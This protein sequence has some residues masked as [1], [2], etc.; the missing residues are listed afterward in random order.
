MIELV[1]TS[2]WG[3]RERDR[4]VK[5]EIDAKLLDDEVATCDAVK[6]E[7]LYSARNATEF[8]AIRS[9]LDA[10]IAYPVGRGEW[11]RALDVYERLAEQGGNH[12]RQVKHMDL[13]VAAA[14]ESA[15]VPVLHCDEDFDRIAK[16]TRQPTRWA[17]TRPE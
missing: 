12:H 4:T 8:R 2:A 11:A 13:L 14:A 6:L 17:S 3:W 10:L 15:G 16:V 5:A 7:L 1:D 9:R